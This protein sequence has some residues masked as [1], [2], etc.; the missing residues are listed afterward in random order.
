MKI[1]ETTRGRPVA[2]DAVPTFCPICGFE[3]AG[4]TPRGE[5]RRARVTSHAVGEHPERLAKLY[6]LHRGVP[7][8]YV[9]VL[10][11]TPP[12]AVDHGPDPVDVILLG[13]IQ[14]GVEPTFGVETFD[15]N[16]PDRPPRYSLEFG[17]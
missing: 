4:V 9:R 13:P 3:L 5:A 10:V 2:I 1:F 16:P 12:L 17:V 15:L 14:E 11:V 7:A 8:S 6:T